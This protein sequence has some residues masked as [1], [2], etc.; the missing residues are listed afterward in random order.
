MSSVTGSAANKA[1]NAKMG[2]RIGKREAVAT[3]M[4][5]SS[6]I[7]GQFKIAGKAVRNMSGDVSKAAGVFGKLGTAA[8]V[9]AAGLRLFGAAALNAIPIVGQV[10]FAATLLYE[11]LTAVFGDPFA[12]NAIEQAAEDSV[13]ALQKM[14]EAGDDITQAMQQAAN[15][16]EA[17]FVKLNARSG[18]A[19]Q[20]ATELRSLA[21]TA[22][23][24]RAEKI[25]QA[26]DALDNAGQGSGL[27]RLFTESDDRKEARRRIM[28]RGGTAQEARA[29][30]SDEIKVMR[31]EALKAAKDFE[32]MFDSSN[33]TDALDAAKTSLIDMGFSE[34]S[35]LLKTINAEMAKIPENSKLSAEQ[36]QAIAEA[37]EDAEKGTKVFV[38]SFNELPDAINQLQGE[39]AKLSRKVKT[40]FTDLAAAGDRV[41][42][43]FLTIQK[44]FNALTEEERGTFNI[45]DRLNAMGDASKE[46][47]SVLKGSDIYKGLAEGVSETEKLT[48]AAVA[49]SDAIDKADDLARKLVSDLEKNKTLQKDLGQFASKNAVF[50]EAQMEA[51]AEALRIRKRANEAIIASFAGMKLTVDQQAYLNGLKEQNEATQGEI[52]RILGDELRKSTALFNESKRQLDLENK[53]LGV[54]RKT[55]E[56]SQQEQ[57]LDNSSELRQLQRN[58]FF[59]I[60]DQGRTAIDQEIKQVEAKLKFEK[61]N[62]ETINAAKTAMIQAEYALLDAQLRGEMEKLR[63]R[64]T[65]M[66]EGVTQASRDQA[67]TSA[68]NLETLIG[69]E[70]G[71]G[72]LGA[73]QTQSVANVAAESEVAVGSL[74]DKLMGLRESKRD[75]MDVN[76]LASGVATSLESNMT[77]ALTALIQ[78]T[79][80]A[81]E[82]FADMAKSIIADI[83]AMIAKQ[84]VFNALKSM[85]GGFLPFAEGG[86]AQGGFTAMAKGGYAPG[87]FR[88]FADGGTVNKPTLGLV[89]EGR[90]NEA[91]VP[92]P[93]G[94]SI[95]VEMKSGGGQQNNVTVNVAID[96]NGQASS[97][98][99]ADGNQGKEIGNMVAAA[100][101][102]ELQHQKR[103]GG[104]LNP[105]G[106]A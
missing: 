21:S 79:K 101:Q 91:I 84:L 69:A 5:A 26:Q 59:E 36:I 54:K 100:V 70:S 86:V 96:Q 63:I 41:E 82:A 15:A 44:E 81:K 50:M 55:F 75:L 106:N 8:K 104:I 2:S 71:G 11:G 88:A 83:A 98:T 73:A 60:L 29:G 10:L 102:Q 74:Q 3:N 13:T 61:D 39:F 45:L 1:R 49:Y 35:P 9:G 93:D 48:I 89:G 22:T 34:A 97:S 58:P 57:K 32:N 80:S 31:Q 51:E 99:N 20:V 66:S 65:D 90:Y 46:F 30:Q 7:V 53:I 67:A 18:F 16:T 12:K 6:G 37:V 105:Y 19:G 27:V 76:V 103:A 68:N 94:R 72:T 23:E 87:G 64:S 4:M 47:V 95:P 52:D 40:P 24:G 56:L 77:G 85:F 42:G 38:E 78:G 17:M 28:E 43:T 25:Q 14:K 92:L 62:Q 33:V